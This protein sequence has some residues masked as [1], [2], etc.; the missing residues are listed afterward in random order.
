MEENKE[1]EITG[2]GFIDAYNLGYEAGK[3]ER[4]AEVDEADRK[5]S[6]YYWK[7]NEAQKREQEACAEIARLKAKNKKLKK[8]LKGLEN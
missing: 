8:Q 5:R 3:R 2:N 6:D 7:M 1:H 4:Q